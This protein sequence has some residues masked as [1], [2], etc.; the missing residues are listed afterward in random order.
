MSNALACIASCLA[1][2]AIG[3]IFFLGLW[4]TLRRAV[5]SKR[6]MTWVVSSFVL[7]FS[8]ALFAFYFFAAEQWQYLL[9]CLLGF[10]LARIGVNS[11]VGLRGARYASQP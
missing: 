2:L 11:F 1:G 5:V 3:G 4:W 8:L 7:R 6:P 10:V 9:Y